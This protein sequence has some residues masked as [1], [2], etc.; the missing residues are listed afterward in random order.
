VSGRVRIRIADA[1]SIDV[2]PPPDEREAVLRLLSRLR[3]PLRPRRVG[4]KLRLPLAEADRL[5][6]DPDLS[7]DWDRTAERAAGNRRTVRARASAIVEQAHEILAADV[8]SARQMLADSSSRVALDD[9]QLVNVAAMTLGGGWGACVFDE[10]G[11]GKTVTTIGAFDVLVERG[12][13]DTL[14]LAAPKSMVAEWQ[15]EF[16]R[17]TG[18]LYAVAVVTGTPRERNAALHS[19]AD[20]LVL[21]Y[22]TAVRHEDDLVLLAQRRK[23][24]LTVDESYNVKNPDAQRSASMRRIREWCERCFV[25]CGTPAPNRADDLI[26]QFDLVD[27]GHTFGGYEP[28][29]DEDLD[30]GA[31]RA[32]ADA[33]GIFT[34]N[35]KRKVLPDLPERSFEDVMVDLAP[36]QARAYR[37]AL[38]DLIV[39]LESTDERDYRRR[40]FSFLERR[41]ALLRIC[42]NPRSLVPNY[43]ETPAK[44]KAL[45]DLLASVLA[46]GDKAVIWSFYRD[47]LDAIAERYADRGLVRVDGTIDDIA[48][49]REAVRAFQEDDGT[50]IFLGNPAAAGAGI[51]LHRARLAIYE[52]ISNQAAH[53]MQSLDRIHRRGQERDC[54]YLLLICRDTIEEEE[55]RRVRDKAL[56]QADLLGDPPDPAPSRRRM[57]D[58]LLHAREVLTT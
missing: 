44:L 39:D 35:L 19:G 21:G 41:A 13:A 7:F 33:R 22:E 10:Q 14:L 32:A 58:E 8:D 57:L 28:T 43:Q 4:D 53:W 36:V 48:L 29:G 25:L 42:S 30:R 18:D 5:L 6:D 46:R 51:T 34:R 15:R 40:I 45:D 11:T 12:E 50:R 24:V 1:D 56:A 27:F 52:S 23:V 16:E 55:F 38:D 26:A 2:I 9:H 17:F 49:R 31:I 3:P 20:V 37:G 54:E 47:S